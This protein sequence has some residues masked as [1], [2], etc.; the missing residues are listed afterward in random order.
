MKLVTVWL[1][2]DGVRNGSSKCAV[3]NVIFEQ[4]LIVSVVMNYRLILRLNLR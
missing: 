1:L 2:E 3:F 4:Q